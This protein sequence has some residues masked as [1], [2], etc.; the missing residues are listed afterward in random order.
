[1]SDS[2]TENWVKT[3]SVPH[4]DGVRTH[5]SNFI[6]ERDAPRHIHQEYVF[7]LAIAGAMEIDC[8]HCGD[9]HILQPNDLLLTE[10]NEVYS[11][12]ALGKPSWQYFSISISK[13]KLGLILDSADSKQITLPHY[14]RGAIKND[15]FRQPQNLS[16]IC[17]DS[18]GARVYPREPP[19]KY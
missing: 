15:K 7:G 10:A 19:R 5:A 9:T 12:R 14:T 13:E 18:P 6:S 8:G 3:Q 11:S 16:R 17:C 1:M 4:L 2:T